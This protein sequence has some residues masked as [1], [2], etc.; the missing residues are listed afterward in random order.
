MNYY[1][2]M[3]ILL[4]PINNTFNIQ[5]LHTLGLYLL[6]QVLTLQY[7]TFSRVILYISCFHT[8]LS[9]IYYVL[10]QLIQ[11]HTIHTRHTLLVYPAIITIL[12]LISYSNTLLP[13][14]RSLLIIIYLL[15]SWYYTWLCT[16]SF[17]TLF[18]LVFL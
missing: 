11:I 13:Y 12:I 4:Y 10:S 8:W 9:L 6:I 2:T 15:L 17:T 3:L 1:I 18:L 16:G 14:Y 5:G 7:Y